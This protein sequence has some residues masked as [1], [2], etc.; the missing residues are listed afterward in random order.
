[1][2]FNLE[3]AFNLNLDE[4]MPQNVHSHLYTH[5]VVSVH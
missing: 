1:M 5:V 4:K 3:S 2:R